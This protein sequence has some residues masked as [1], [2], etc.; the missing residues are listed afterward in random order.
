VAVVD[1]VATEA[2]TRTS[3]VDE[4]TQKIYLPTAKAAPS[5]VGGRGTFLPNTFKVLVIGNRR[6]APSPPVRAHVC[7]NAHKH[8]FDSRARQRQRQM[9]VI[10]EVMMV[11]W[12]EDDRLESCVRRETGQSS[13]EASQKP[14]PPHQQRS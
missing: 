14:N 1:T 6:V 3:G 5:P 12:A 8:A 7:D 9:M 11:A 4:Q 10:D 2:G 13:W